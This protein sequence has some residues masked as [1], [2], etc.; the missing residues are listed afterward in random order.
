MFKVPWF[1]ACKY[2]ERYVCHGRGDKY[3]HTKLGLRFRN[4]FNELVDA[5]QLLPMPGFDYVPAITEIVV[6]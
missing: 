1:T 6:I 4:N 3:I 2:G 5:K